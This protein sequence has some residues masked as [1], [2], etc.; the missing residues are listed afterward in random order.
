MN[1]PNNPQ[2]TQKK[3]EILE[4]KNLN[5]N[6][7]CMWFYTAE[8]CWRNENCHFAHDIPLDNQQKQCMQSA[9][10]NRSR[11]RSINRSQSASNTKDQATGS[12]TLCT[13]WLAGHCKFGEKCIFSHECAKGGNP[14]A[15]PS[16]SQSGQKGGTWGQGNAS[17]LIAD[18][19]ANQGYIG[20]LLS[21][22]SADPNDPSVT[23]SGPLVITKR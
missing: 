15:A 20:Y 17:C 22:D 13:N 19:P 16:G 10:A 23:T 9:A 18:G 1:F 14:S 6:S 12:R 4:L 3:K 21:A 2:L 8:G 11:S 5:G 7:P